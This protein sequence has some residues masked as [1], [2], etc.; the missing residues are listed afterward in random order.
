M[1]SQDNEAQKI[2]AAALNKEGWLSGH[3][4]QML[5]F[6]N[7]LILTVSAFI[8]LNIFIDQLI[9]DNINAT[10]Y[11]T[12]E[13]LSEK[14]SELEGNIHAA[15]AILA[16]SGQLAASTV[17]AT[18]EQS[19]KGK[20][21]FDQIYWLERQ[22][23]GEYVPHKMDDGE[24][25][26]LLENQ[27][28]LHD[29]TIKALQQDK[30][31]LRLLSEYPGF[32]SLA[33]QNDYPIILANKIKRADGASDIV[34]GLSRIEHIITPS[35]FENRKNI[36]S[37]SAIFGERN[38]GMYRYERELQKDQPWE[39]N[40]DTY[41]KNFTLKLADKS[42]FVTVVFN[43]GE[44]ELFLKKIPYLILLFGGVLTLIGTL[45]VRNNQKQALKL[46]QM[47]VEM[48]NKNVD[49]GHEVAE[50]EKLN[51]ALRQAEKENRAVIDAVSDIIFET[52]TMGQIL[53]VNETWH[54]ITGFSKERSLGRNLF[55]LLPTQDQAEQRSNFSQLVKGRKEGYRAYTR[56]RTAEGTFRSVELAISMLRQ[57]EN[58]DMRVVGT[59]T[60]VEDRRRTERALGEAEKKYRA[61]VENAA[62]GIYQV[63]PEGQYLS[64]NPAFAHILGYETPEDILRDVHNANADIYF[65][66][67]E[68]ERQLRDAVR[69]GHVNIEAQ[70]RRK[71]GAII[72]LRENLR[73]VKD[74]Q[75]Q[76]LFFEGSIED[77]TLQKTTELEL[78]KAKVNS[79]LASRAKSEFL[80]NMSHE[81]RTPLNAIIGFSDIIQTEAFGSVGRKE[82]LDYARD[83]N[84]SGKR[85]LQVINEILDVS[86][87]EA[88]ERQLNEGL[89][90]L[91]KV[92]GSALEMLAGKIESGRMI[93]SNYISPATPK[94]IGEG[95]AIKQMLMNLL[96]NALKFTP[97]GGR[98]TLQAT[99]D[100]DGQMH[101]SITDTGIGLSDEEIE[102]ALSPFGQV[103]NALSK[104]ESGTGL[105]L[106]LVQSLMSLHG[107]S[108]EM[109]SQKGV[110]TTATLIFPP[111]RVSQHT[112]EK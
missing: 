39:E 93:V 14:F 107:G 98:I 75:E 21:F 81:L 35:Y 74:E 108:F 79:D 55:D 19:Y 97:D 28:A 106:T 49:L 92:V 65:N 31:G 11:E 44:R 105:G 20:N 64:A 87:I 30:T 47:N 102:K 2:M 101:I 24:P 1:P 23:D 40:S 90:D 25:S 110:G 59:I 36:A 62:S 45:Y 41:R 53:F 77:I 95:Q 71:D 43:L 78:R 7:G 3:M 111:K 38:L 34:Y 72:W 51:Q 50:R 91:H 37:L 8:M 66:G 103:N 80:A 63:T 96:S 9:S 85:L 32:V 17:E 56:L 94:I 104:H 10:S 18:F 12:E 86:R 42:I 15:S 73:A 48:A 4:T 67:R 84:H 13:Y 26:G 29:F 89:V 58:K 61:I 76:L 22:A 57:D 52:D 60:D 69:F 46:I 82:Y 33:G 99:L 112:Q 88:G 27:A 83:I 109:F 100:D 16:F 5:V 6:L 70:A 68:R 54:K